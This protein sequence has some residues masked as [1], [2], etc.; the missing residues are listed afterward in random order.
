MYRHRDTG[1]RV[2]LP[3]HHGRIIPPGTLENILRQAGLTSDE[4]KEL[5]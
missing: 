4:L 1:R 3:Y 2:T 5:L